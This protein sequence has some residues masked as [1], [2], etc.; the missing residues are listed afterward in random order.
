MNVFEVDFY[1]YSNGPLFTLWSVCVIYSSQVVSEE[2][3][4][5]A[6]EQVK[7]K[8]SKLDATV[9]CAGVGVAFKIYNFNK[10][11]AHDLSDFK[12]VSWLDFYNRK[13][14]HFSDLIMPLCEVSM[15]PKQTP[16]SAS[17][18]PL[19]AGEGS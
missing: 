10:D 1:A 16:V 9:N 17:L 15:I 11:L 3:V 8:F 2:D 4:K 14:L 6:L 13:M 5:A 12:R 18:C 7:N 19:T